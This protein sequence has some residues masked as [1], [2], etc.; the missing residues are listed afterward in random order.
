MRCYG[1]AYWRSEV[2]IGDRSVV[3][4]DPGAS[5]GIVTMHVHRSKLRM[6]FYMM[7]WPQEAKLLRRLACAADGVLVERFRLYAPTHQMG[8]TF[9]AV[10]VIGML[11]EAVGDRLTFQDPAVQAQV[12]SRELDEYVSHIPANEH[13]R[14][15]LRHAYIL[16]RRLEACSGITKRKARSS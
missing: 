7:S 5:C 12:S 11:R 2:W 8:S 4:I 6:R 1:G 13:C 16:V 14:A 9:P 3:V 15:A 10:E